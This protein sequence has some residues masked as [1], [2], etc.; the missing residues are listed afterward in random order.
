[1]VF[2]TFRIFVYFEIVKVDAFVGLFYGCDGF[3][4]DDI[5]F[6]ILMLARGQSACAMAVHTAAADDVNGGD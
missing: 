2:V 4:W 1:M 6:V 5:L 3:G